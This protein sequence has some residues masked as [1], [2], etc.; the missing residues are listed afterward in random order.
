MNP[1]TAA[2]HGFSRRVWLRTRWGSLSG[3]SLIDLILIV[4]GAGLTAVSVVVFLNPND[5][6]PGGFTALAM[7]ANRLWGWPVGVTL[8][9]MN[10]PFLLVAMA[11]LGMQF[12]PRTILATVLASTL[13]DVLQP[14]LPQVQGDPLLYTLYGGLL[15]GVGLG[16]VFRA[17]ATTGGVEIPAKLLEH[18]RGVRMSSSLLA[19][20]AAVLVLA[21]F[22]FGL[23]SALYALIVAWVAARVIDFMETGA[24]AS[25]TA[26]I[27]TR[28]PETIRD[29]ILERLERGVTLLE[30]QGGYTGE[31]RTVLMAVVRRRET[32]TLQEIVRV[33][34]PEAFVVI[35]PSHEVLGEGFKPLTRVGRRP[36][37]PSAAA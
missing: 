20:D 11:V 5:V 22:F 4:V 25:I 6:V 19:M 10:L 14:Y 18:W 24:T 36:A 13:I 2:L 29:G 30:G 8:L 7:F 37:G 33:A 21:A 31:Q 23:E 35:S 16:L 15:Y 3:R 17:N 12:G 32:R 27:I 26:F 28:Q 34:D 9:I 1:W